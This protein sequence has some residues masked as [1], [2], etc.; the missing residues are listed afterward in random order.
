[1]NDALCRN[2]H[3]IDDIEKR[4]VI[5]PIGKRMGVGWFVELCIGSGCI[6]EVSCETEV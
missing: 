6:P 4:R 2:I 1:M 3:Q 5:V